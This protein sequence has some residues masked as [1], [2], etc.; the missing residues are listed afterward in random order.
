MR[1]LIETIIVNLDLFT[2]GFAV[3]ATSILGALVYFQNPRS[4]TNRSFLAFA[5]F[6]A[7]WGI[8]N[9]FS[10]RVDNEVWTLWSLRFVMF[11]ATGQALTLFLLFVT[12]P[13]SEL[14]RAWPIRWLAVPLALITAGATLT[15]YIF[16][17]LV[18]FVA[19]T[20]PDVVNGPLMPLFALTNVGLVLTGI[21]TL[22]IKTTRAK[23]GERRPFWVL[24]GG[25]LLMFGLIITFNFVLP[26][27]YGFTLLI[28]LAALFSF[29]FVLATTY[30]IA[31]YRLFKLRIVSAELFV[32]L[33]IILI[34]GEMVTETDTGRILTDMAV[35]IGLIGV[36]V[37]LIK[38]IFIEVEQKERL[39]EMTRDLQDANV[40]L[41]QLDRVRSEFLSFASHQVK[42]P[43]SVVK[44]YAQLIV[45]GTFGKVPEKVVDTS[46]KIKES[47]DRLIALVNNLLDLRR[48][49]EGRME[50]A[51]ETTD[52]GLLAEQTI[53]DLQTLAE[54]KHLALT[55]NGPGTKLPASIDLVKFRQ[56]IQNLVENAIKY[57]DTG[58]VTVTAK[59]VDGTITVSVSD[60][61]R[62]MAPDLIPELF[63]QFTREKNAA[64]RIEG[65]GLGLYIA[66]QI[67]LGHKGTISA[68]S[69]GSGKGSTFVVTI[70][71]NA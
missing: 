53:G 26:A 30:A 25:T 34:L 15:P 55:Y 1:E 64:K 61:G 71:A 45:D 60:T 51:F 6:T 17:H 57:T 54:Q 10:Y 44:G 38:N 69:E 66:K 7:G 31:Q 3:A 37:M 23:R 62:G 22:L 8:A 11:G 27:F 2:V 65:T 28:P 36:G 20:I 56:V 46:K 21:G 32:F 50:F 35:F 63:D 70:P 16:S 24:L 40:K 4:A 5:L 67:V 29:P 14:P 68:A 39:E 41:K 12:F 13:N 59:R 42:A 47:A 18:T 19:G 52:V 33:L 43:M 9:Y 49:E 48:I 58:S